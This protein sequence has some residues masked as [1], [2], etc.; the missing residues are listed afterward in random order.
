LQ[1]VHYLHLRQRRKEYEKEETVQRPG[2]I[3]AIM[4]AAARLKNLYKDYQKHYKNFKSI[5]GYNFKLVNQAKDVWKRMLKF[6][7]K[8]DID[9]TAVT[10]QGD[11]DASALTGRLVEYDP[12]ALQKKSKIT[13]TGGQL[14]RANGNLVDT[15]NS[16]TFQKGLGWEIFVMSP[17]G[18]IHMESHKIGKY[19]H[20]SLL[21]GADVASAG[22]M[23]VE[24]GA[25]RELS[26]HSGHYAPTLIHVL[27]ILQR[28]E[29]KGVPLTFDLNIQA[30]GVAISKPADVFWAE[31]QGKR[32]YEQ[33]KTAQ[34]W[35]DFV[36]KY[37]QPTVEKRFTSKKWKVTQ[38]PP[39]V[40]IRELKCEKPDGTEATQKEIREF[41]KV[42]LGWKKPGFF[43]WLFSLGK[44]KKKKVPVTPL[45]T[46]AP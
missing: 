6:I 24:N 18:D 17:T 16:V 43:K 8:Q 11:F 3:G 32:K 14:K 2:L 40:G 39:T 41:L 45:V 36:G 10:D 13:I 33:D 38:V 1:R 15:A 27:Q 46:E 25:L 28:L 23:R 9:K 29:K 31:P 7:R 34:M 37:G 4:G 21:A 20:S 42:N 35:D 19:H 26:N 44:A 5:P 12:A 30:G 22:M